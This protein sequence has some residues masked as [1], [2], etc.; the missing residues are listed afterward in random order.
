ML[1]DNTIIAI[2]T[3]T[4]VGAISIVRLSGDKALEIVDV[5]FKNKSKKKLIN[6]KTNTSHYGQIVDKD[7][8]IDEVIVT[9]YK[10]PNSFTGEDTVEISCHLSLI[11]I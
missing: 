7:I 5:F 3:P 6:Q 4:G 2:S 1:N 8:L 9:I 10:N 11:H